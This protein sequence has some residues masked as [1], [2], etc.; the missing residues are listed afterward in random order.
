MS[1]FIK[2]SIADD[3][4]AEADVLINGQH[5]GETGELVTLGGPGWVNVSVDRSGAQSRDVDVEHTTA[6]HPM[7]VEIKCA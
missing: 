2:V 5:N 6:S 3:H 4:D 1:E 7:Q